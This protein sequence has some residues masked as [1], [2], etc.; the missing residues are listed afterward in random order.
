[1]MTASTYTFHRRAR[2][3]LNQLPEA[4]QKQLLER[5]TTFFEI[6]VEQW[7]AVWAKRLPGNPSL[8]LVRINDSLRVFVEVEDGRPPEVVDL[9]RQKTLEAFAK[10]A[11]K[12]GK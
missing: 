4:E 12:T 2:T 3:A 8:Y 1:M 5:L 10:A 11:E 6:P 9:V 7:P